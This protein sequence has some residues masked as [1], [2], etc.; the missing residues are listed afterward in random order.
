MH[1]DT[2]T[3]WASQTE[4]TRRLLQLRAEHP[5]FRRRALPQRGD[6]ARRGGQAERVGR[7]WP[8][9][10]AGGPRCRRRNGSDGTRRTLGMYLAW[11][12]PDRTN[13]DAFLIWFHGGADPI[14][15]D[16]PDGP[17]AHTYSVLLHTGIDGELPAEKI[18]AGSSCRSP[19]GRSWCSR[20]TRT[21]GSGATQNSGTGRGAPAASSTGDA[22]GA[23]SGRGTP[24]AATQRGPR[25]ARSGEPRGLDHRHHRA[26]HRHAAA[27]PG[28]PPACGRPFGAPV[29]DQLPRWRVRAGKSH[30]CRLAVR[31]ARRPGRGGRGLGGVP[32]GAGAPSAEAVPGRL[33]RNPLA[34]RER[35]TAR[36]R[37][38]AGDSAR[39]ERRGQPRGAGRPGQPGPVPRRAELADRSPGRSWPIRRWT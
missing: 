31:P 14:Q 38:A 15:V 6:A 34:G 28:L 30:Q 1:W 12:D 39:G 17:W 3:R 9:S 7:I 35:R 29:G 4:L 26:E 23:L 22:V 27:G 18:V 5:V 10:G 37:P 32:A 2:A 36:C 16:L 8:G 33:D 20:S 25:A 11:D 24:R 21:G 19:A 13:D